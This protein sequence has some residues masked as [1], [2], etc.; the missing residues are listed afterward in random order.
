MNLEDTNM[1]QFDQANLKFLL[2]CN[3]QQLR[4]WYN[5]VSDDDLRY[6][7]ELM[8]RYADFL[9]TEVR[10]QR[11]ELELQSMPVMVEAQAVIAM[12]RG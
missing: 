2:N 12:I 1:D 10:A 6:A 9:E 7:S 5:T 4:E 3:S 8:E 11:I